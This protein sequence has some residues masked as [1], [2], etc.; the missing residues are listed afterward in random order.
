MKERHAALLDY[1]MPVSYTHLDVYKRQTLHM[2]S[3]VMN[4]LLTPVGVHRNSLSLS[5]TEKLPSF[6]A[7]MPRL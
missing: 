1:V 2:Y 6:A 4:P 5:F 7:T 3:G